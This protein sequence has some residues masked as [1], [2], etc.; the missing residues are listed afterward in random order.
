MQPRMKSLSTL[1]ERI[2]KIRQE[3]GDPKYIDEFNHLKIEDERNERVKRAAIMA[4]VDPSH[5]PL[6]RDP[7]LLTRFI[8]ILENS[9]G[10]G[11]EIIGILEIGSFANGEGMELSDVD[12]RVYVRVPDAY[13]L[14]VAGHL[15]SE[16]LYERHGA[17]IQHVSKKFGSKP[18]LSFSF[19]DFNEPLWDE[20]QVELGL[21]VEFGL[22]DA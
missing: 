5:S 7:S 20:V 22:S 12:T 19:V 9:V 8:E 18:L 10:H 4:G 1:A 3:R 11:V 15:A 17:L 13:V 14:N 6:E 2:T 16:K 21:R